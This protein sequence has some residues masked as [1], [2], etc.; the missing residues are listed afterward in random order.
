MKGYFWN[1]LEK[2]VSITNISLASLSY[3][4]VVEYIL[5]FNSWGG[6]NAIDIH[7]VYHI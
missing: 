6:S 7:I 5:Q 1:H 2:H 3:R 4:Y